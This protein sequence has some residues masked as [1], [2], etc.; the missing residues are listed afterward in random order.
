MWRTYINNTP[1]GVPYVGADRKVEQVVKGEAKLSVDVD[2]LGPLEA[3]GVP[4]GAF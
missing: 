2:V 4:G 1:R 3:G